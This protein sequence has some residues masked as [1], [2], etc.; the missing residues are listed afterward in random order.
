LTSFLNGIRKPAGIDCVVAF[1]IAQNRYRTYLLFALRQVYS[2]VLV[3]WDPSL[4]DIQKL[5]PEGRRIFGMNGVSF[6]TQKAFGGLRLPP[7]SFDFVRAAN[8]PPTPPG[9]GRAFDIE[10]DLGRPP[11]PDS[12]LFPYGPHPN[13]FQHRPAAEDRATDARKQRRPL[14]V[15]FSGRM[16]PSPEHDHLLVERNF[17]VPCRHSS[18]GELKRSYPDALWVDDLA[19]RMR[20][21][22]WSSGSQIPLCFA[23]VKGDPRHWLNELASADFFLCL[24]GSHML[25]CHNAVEAI[26]AGCV[27]ILCY[28]NWFSPNLVSG[29]NC[30]SYRTLDELKRAIDRALAMTD[31]EV[32]EM[33][34]RV[35]DY[36]QHHLDCVQAARRVF[37]REHPYKALTVYLNQEDCDNY[38]AASADSVLFKGGSLQSVL[39]ERR[40][41]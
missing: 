35:I 17:H 10:I 15:F 38:T 27:P 8:G 16:S 12:Y 40:A 9:A 18:L 30:L 28:E 24:P 29:V 26:S 14:R 21:D 25:M 37:G 19:K 23:T 1:P 33:R 22:Q 6:V 5:F 7:G 4:Q 36:Y 2:R 13:N 39:D 41:S 3:V 34:S 11:V 32:A 20:F 31:A